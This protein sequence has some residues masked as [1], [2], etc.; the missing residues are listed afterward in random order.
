M[1]QS[2]P[3][4]IF[5]MRSAYPLAVISFG[6]AAATALSTMQPSGALHSIVCFM[7]SFVMAAP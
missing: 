2:A 1:I 7:P 5:A 4:G 3:A 6:A